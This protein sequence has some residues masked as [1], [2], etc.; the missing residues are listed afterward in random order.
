LKKYSKGAFR[1]NEDGVELSGE[2]SPFLRACIGIGIL[3]LCLT[4]PLYVFL[5]YS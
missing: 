4:P 2:F 5:R 1:V 3:L